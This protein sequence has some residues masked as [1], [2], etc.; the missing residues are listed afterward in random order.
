M[1]PLALIQQS[2][3]R[4]NGIISKVDIF[5]FLISYYAV[6]R[7]RWSYLHI[8]QI[9]DRSEIHCI[10][11]DLYSS[12]VTSYVLSNKRVVSNNYLRTKYFISYV[13]EHYLHSTQ[14][15]ATINCNIKNNLDREHEV[16]LS[17]YK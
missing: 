6:G 5:H 17:H 13:L 9:Q 10:K 2:F 4:F 15:D 1:Y 16:T 14:C 3:E 7:M 12:R 8:K 11:I